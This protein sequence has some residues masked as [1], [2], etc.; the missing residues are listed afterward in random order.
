MT[1]V[2]EPIRSRRNLSERRA[3]HK[4]DYCAH[5]EM[6][7]KSRKTLWSY[8]KDG[9]PSETSLVLD[10]AAEYWKT[11]FEKPSPP[12]N[13]PIVPLGNV[14]GCWSPLT[15]D[16][17]IKALGNQRE[18]APGPDDVEYSQ[19][20]KV[21]VAVILALLNSFMW[22]STV[23]GSLKINRT[24]LIPKKAIG[25]ADPA[26]YRPITMSPVII[27][28]LNSVLS[29]RLSAHLELCSAQRGFVKTDGCFENIVLLDWV[30]RRCIK[31]N[32]SL[33]SAFA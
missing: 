15:A 2:A 27:R 26:D 3:G 12:D 32:K 6:W 30:I 24:V 22:L 5:Q 8:I 29:S 1:K 10:S 19:L 11:Y 18:K 7:R 21:P 14:R 23:P 17:V 25:S 9:F 16:E 31:R 33:V 4:S 28:V 13:E 20:K